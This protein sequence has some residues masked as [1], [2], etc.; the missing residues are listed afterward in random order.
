[1]AKILNLIIV[2]NVEKCI[3]FECLKNFKGHMLFLALCQIM[4]HTFNYFDT[5]CHKLHYFNGT[6]FPLNLGYCW[7]YRCASRHTAISVNG[8]IIIMEW[9][10]NL[11]G[12]HIQA[13]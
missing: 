5:C 1:M 3:I 13:P 10:Y 9:C 2:Q 8:S 11:I 7:T 12:H 4:Q 6:T